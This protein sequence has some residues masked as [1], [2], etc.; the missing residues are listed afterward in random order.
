VSSGVFSCP[1][2]KGKVPQ[3]VIDAL[4]ESAEPLKTMADLR[5]SKQISYLDKT[6]IIVRAVDTQRKH[7]FH[8]TIDE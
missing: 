1:V 5:K 6:S 7:H 3:K 2:Y 8:K 4:R